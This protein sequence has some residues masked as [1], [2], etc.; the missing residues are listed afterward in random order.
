[1]GHLRWFFNQLAPMQWDAARCSRTLNNAVHNAVLHSPKG[2]RFRLPPS[3][4]GE[5]LP[6]TDSRR[7]PPALCRTSC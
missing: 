2:Q 5:P 6:Y 4:A 7:C 1:M 3:G